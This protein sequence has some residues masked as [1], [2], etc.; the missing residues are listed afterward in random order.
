M[1]APTLISVEEYL[2]ASYEP[3]CDYIDGEVRERNMGEGPHSPMQMALSALCYANRKRWQVR[4]LPEQRAQTSARRF[5]VPDVYLISVHDPMEDILRI[6]PLLCIE[7]VSSEQSL[8]D[9]QDR[10]DDY[11]AMGVRQV[12]VLDPIRRCAFVPGAGGQ[13][14]QHNRVLTVAETPIQLEIEKIFLEFDELAA[15]R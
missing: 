2:H 11:L 7:I 3:D 15:G 5:R 4:P 10:T 14:Q 6:P 13:L 9:M 8:R 12:W 1:A